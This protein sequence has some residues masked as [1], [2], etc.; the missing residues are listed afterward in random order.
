MDESQWSVGPESVGHRLDK[1]LAS[2]DRLASRGRAVAAIERGKVF[3]NEIEATKAD[4][5]R[6]LT[7]GD[8]VRGWVDRPGHSVRRRRPNCREQAIGPAD[9]ATRSARRGGGLGARV[10]QALLPDRSGA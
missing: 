9:G 10:A 4:A 1:F 8:R 2:A 6:R 5:A 7:Q 3:V